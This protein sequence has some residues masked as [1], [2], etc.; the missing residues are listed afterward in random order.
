MFPGF[1]IRS[2]AGLNILTP[3]FVKTLPCLCIL[4]SV[5]CVEGTPGCGA[6]ESGFVWGVCAPS[7]TAP[8]LFLRG[9]TYL[10]VQQ[11]RRTSGPVLAN[12]T[13]CQLASLLS[14]NGVWLRR[15]PPPPRP[16]HSMHL[17]A[18]PIL[19]HPPSLCPVCV[20]EPY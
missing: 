5:Y 3:T 18:G 4:C 11:P 12:S 17:C 13:F 10:H 20:C 15:G 1:Q 7:H 9:V 8:S 16:T 14:E 19:C 2:H 6:P